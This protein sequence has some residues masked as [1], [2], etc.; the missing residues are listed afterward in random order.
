MAGA[1]PIQSWS[2]TIKGCPNLPD[3]I[4]KGHGGV[5]SCLAGK[6]R[7]HQPNS[8]KEQLSRC[9]RDQ[10][11][12][13]SFLHAKERVRVWVRVRVSLP[14]NS[15]QAWGKWRRMLDAKP[16]RG[17]PS[18]SKAP[19]PVLR[20]PSLSGPGSLQNQILRVCI[21]V[22]CVNVLKGANRDVSRNT[23]VLS[24]W[25]NRS[26]CHL[27]SRKA[28]WKITEP[29]IREDHSPQQTEDGGKI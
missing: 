2:R 20:P 24:C 3:P 5:S 9:S 28:R 17:S 13:L 25:R 29:L 18:W 10:H 8:S 19:A 11:R 12:A 16:P 7:P 14:G 22:G 6:E 4:L 15:D 26:G 1:N 23:A 27:H 21:C